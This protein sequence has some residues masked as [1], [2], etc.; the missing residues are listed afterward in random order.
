LRRTGQTAAKTARTTQI[1]PHFSELIF[2]SYLLIWA[3]TLN[4]NRFFIS[5]RHEGNVVIIN[6][7]KTKAPPSKKGW[8]L[9]DSKVV[10]YVWIWMKCEELSFSFLI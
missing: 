7:F 4:F 5:F 1:P 6:P 9:V 3:F 2:F 8:G 10:I